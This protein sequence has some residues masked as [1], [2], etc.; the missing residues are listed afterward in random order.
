MAQAVGQL[1]C[2]LR[3]ATQRRRLP[4]IPDA[5]RC[6]LYAAAQSA[7]CASAAHCWHGTGMRRVA[8]AAGHKATSRSAATG[9]ADRR[10]QAATEGHPVCM[11]TLAPVACHKQHAAHRR[12][13]LRS[14][15]CTGT[16]ESMR[17]VHPPD[18]WRRRSGRAASG[19]GI[20]RL[21]KPP[22]RL[23]P[24]YRPAIESSDCCRA[25]ATAFFLSPA[26]QL[27]SALLRPPYKAGPQRPE[28]GRTKIQRIDAACFQREQ[29]R[30]VT[31]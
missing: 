22:F 15:K 28:M 30:A 16:P 11:C 14:Y 10:R 25:A 3:Q 26:R 23:Y 24:D 13:I 2:L 8:S 17:A 7:G 12:L 6:V 4:S 19:G 1:P 9:A 5:G 29:D 18:W 31:R 27:P 21:T 20:G